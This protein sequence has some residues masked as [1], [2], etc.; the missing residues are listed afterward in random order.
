MKEELI[1]NYTKEVKPYYVKT[2]SY[3]FKWNW[4]K[5]TLLFLKLIKEYE[6]SFVE[7]K[8]KVIDKKNI[9]KQIIAM[10]NE[11]MI[12]NERIDYIVVGR[13]QARLLDDEFV[14][15]T[16]SSQFRFS[17]RG[18]RTFRDIDIVINPFIDGI[19]P[20]LK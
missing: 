20:I 12:N 5:K 7:V 8:S 2:D 18:I 11:F 10:L 4:L 15:I 13:K 17:D 1:V 9:E 16:Y 19:V 3:K 6:D 14:K